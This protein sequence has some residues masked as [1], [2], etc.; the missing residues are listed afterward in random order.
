[1]VSSPSAVTHLACALRETRANAP[2][3]DKASSKSNA[4]SRSVRCA[5]FATGAVVGFDSRP[6]C[7]VFSQL[8]GSNHMIACKMSNHKHP[9]IVLSILEAA[10]AQEVK[11]HSYVSPSLT[12]VAR[13]ELNLS[14]L[15]KKTKKMRASFMA[16]VSQQRQLEH[17]QT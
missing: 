15:P 1:M 12:V 17:Q 11:T 10:R 3:F 14:N 5:A 2:D 8:N 7:E 9:A 4:R 13:S 6:R 16:F